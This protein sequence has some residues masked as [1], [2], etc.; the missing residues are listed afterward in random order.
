MTL[1]LI[2]VTLHDVTVVAADG[3]PRASWPA[4]GGFARVVEHRVAEDELPTDRG[5]V[6][7][8]LMTYQDKIEGLPEEVADT[9][10]IV[11]RVLAAAVSRR[12]DLYFPLDEVRDDTG[13]IVGCRS[14]GRFSIDEE[15]RGAADA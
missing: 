2:N 3:S 10:Y 15:D 7:V 4:S 12:R 11:S 6:P 13:R 8:V 9:A 5:P 1:S 14:L